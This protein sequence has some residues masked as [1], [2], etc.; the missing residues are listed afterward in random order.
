MRS[1]AK[2]KLLACIL[3]VALI[4]PCFAMFPGISAA[5]TTY[6]SVAADQAASGPE[7]ITQ[8]LPKPLR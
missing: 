4:V 8:R 7:V 5:T 3:A 1:N 2:T 6:F